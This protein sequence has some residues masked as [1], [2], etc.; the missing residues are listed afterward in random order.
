MSFWSDPVGSISDTL[1]GSKG[2]DALAL[3]AL[4]VGITNPELL[5]LGGTE[6]ITTP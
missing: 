5:G 3:G 6:A 1:G 2:L 4:A